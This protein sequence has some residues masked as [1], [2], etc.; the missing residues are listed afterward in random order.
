M[1]A[2]NQRIIE[3]LLLS[4]RIYIRLSELSWLKVNQAKLVFVS[5]NGCYLKYEGQLE[6]VTAEVI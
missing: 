5:P 2:L 3:L 1:T 6:S 4:K